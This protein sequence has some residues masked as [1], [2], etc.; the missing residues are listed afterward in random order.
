MVDK[1]EI[2]KLI[3]EERKKISCDENRSLSDWLFLIEHYVSG[4]KLWLRFSQEE[5]VLEK[6]CKV[7]ALCLVCMEVIGR[8]RNDI[9]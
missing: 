6:I 3:E 4:A 7:A 5:A 2:Y 9:D 8:E 1:Q